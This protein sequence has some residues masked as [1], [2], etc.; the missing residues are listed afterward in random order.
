MNLHIAPICLGDA[1][2]F[3]LERKCAIDASYP[4]QN[5]FAISVIDDDAKTIGMIAMSADGQHCKL[6]H[7]YTDGT[8]LVGSILYGAAWRAAKS[9]GYRSVI[10]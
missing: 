10:I 1:H 8:A 2:N 3:F 7:L 4:H 5:G 9:L 6:A